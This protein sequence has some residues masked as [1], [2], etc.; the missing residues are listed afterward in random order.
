MVNKLVECL[1][2]ALDSNAGP[3]GI[4]TGCL[5]AQS[6]QRWAVCIF[7]TVTVVVAALAQTPLTFQ[8]FY[9]D[10]NQLVKVV[11]STGVVIQYVYDPVGNI[12]QVLRSSVAPGALTIFNFTPQQG[13]PFAS[14]T[15]SG[16]G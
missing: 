6:R 7:T 14:V 1:R 16:Q 10:L 2:R 15:V 8:Y 3:R 5:M 12:Q 4:S 9:D 11:D 13:G